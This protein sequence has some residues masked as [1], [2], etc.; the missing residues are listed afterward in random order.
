MRVWLDKN[1]LIEDA[2]V[3]VGS[4]QRKVIERSGAGLDGVASIDLGFRGRAIVL[5]G[6]I[7]AAS[8]EGLDVKVENISDLMDGSSHIVSVEDGR[9]FGDLRVDEFVTE[10]R[11]FGGSGVSCKCKLKFTQLK[12]S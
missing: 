10:E 5:D 7:R 2:V 1:I 9:V 4:C 3:A 8:G 12:I 11:V 6:S